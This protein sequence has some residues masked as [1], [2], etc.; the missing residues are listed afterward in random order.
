MMR[1][2]DGSRR[3]QPWIVLAVAVLVALAAF[4]GAS[5]AVDW[6][7]VLAVA[8]TTGL[9]LMLLWALVRMRYQREEHLRYHALCDPLTGLP[10][11]SLFV[12][13]V[14]QALARVV[15]GPGSVAVLIVDLDDF[16]DINH[17]FGHGAGDRLLRAIA[18]RLEESAG[19]ESTVARLCGDEFA[20]LMEYAPE[21]DAVISA[22]E[23]IGETLRLPVG[24]GKSEVS[25]SASVGVAVGGSAGDSPE[26]LLREADVA[27]HE[28]KRNGKARHEVFDPG[29]DTTTSGRLLVEA[30]LRRAIEEEELLVYYQPLVVLETGKV[31]GVEALVRWRH[32]TYGLIPPAEFVPL[33]EQT[34]LIV[35]IGRWVLEEACRQVRRWQGEHPN[36]PPLTLS[37]NVSACQLRQPNLVEEVFRTLENAEFDPCHLK[38]EITESVLVNDRASTAALRKLKGAGIELLMDD[39]GTGYSNLSYLKRLPVE[40]LKIDRSYVNGLGSNA[41]D[42]AIVHATVAFAKA[43]KLDIT[44]EGIENDGQLAR[45]KD[46]G[47]E[48]GQGYY[49]AKPLPGDEAAEFLYAPPGR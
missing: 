2:F 28:A 16:E 29:A 45:L 42:T 38:L 48:L 37:V 35:P 13:R 32:P 21:K 30:E 7:T 10:N 14:E 6:P 18:Q 19:P 26:G 23:R 5:R 22:A 8:F 31:R 12:K 36:D 40:A 24:L 17:S 15:S 49:F 25:I 39:F 9:F 27:M 44:A 4:Y 47:C 46:L 41:E 20:V 33:A 11:R 3:V 34:G 1:K 43:L